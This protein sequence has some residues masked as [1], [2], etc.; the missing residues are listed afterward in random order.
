MTGALAGAGI[1]GLGN[2]VFGNKKKSL[3]N[4]L[5]T[6][7]AVGGGL[8]GGVGYFTGKNEEAAPAMSSAVSPKPDTKDEDQENYRK[9]M[10][11]TS[12]QYSTPVTKKYKNLGESQDDI[13]TKEVAKL[14]KEN[15]NIDPYVRQSLDGTNPS[16]EAWTAMRDKNNI[17]MQDFMRKAMNKINE[18]KANL[19]KAKENFAKNQASGQLYNDVTA[20]NFPRYIDPNLLTSTPENK[21][22]VFAPNLSYYSKGNQKQL[23]ENAQFNL[24]NPFTDSMGAAYPPSAMGGSVPRIGSPTNADDIEIMR[25]SLGK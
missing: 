3:L 12:P 11:N 15:P 7:G 1:G 23:A 9:S 16:E 4:R 25:R 5:L 14:M 2:A 17:G 22:P 19:A 20:K 24:R 21:P 8:G 13:L 10:T 18:T 6:G